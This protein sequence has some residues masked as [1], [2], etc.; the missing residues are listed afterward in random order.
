VPIP[1]AH[2]VYVAPQK[3]RWL[4]L[5]TSHSFPLFLSLSNL[6]PKHLESPILRQFHSFELENLHI[7]KILIQSMS[8][9][10]KFMGKSLPLII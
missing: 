10:Q 3:R 6:N 5:Q 2:T 9:Y 7:S 4:D 1:C 8:Y